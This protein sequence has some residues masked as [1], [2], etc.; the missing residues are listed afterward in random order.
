MSGFCHL[1]LQ[2]FF[3]KPFLVFFGESFRPTTFSRLP[4]LIAFLVVWAFPPNAP[5][6]PTVPQ[7]SFFPFFRKPSFDSSQPFPPPFFSYPVRDSS[8]PYDFAFRFFTHYCFPTHSMTF[9]FPMISPQGRV[10]GFFSSSEPV[11]D[12]LFFS[13]FSEV[14][15][16]S[17]RP[18]V[19]PH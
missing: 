15:L 1:Y 7:F 19:D 10:P 17:G 6:F 12:P 8:S 11:L 5:A 18:R 14:Q 2:P 3:S 4:I 13:V 9:L 16:P